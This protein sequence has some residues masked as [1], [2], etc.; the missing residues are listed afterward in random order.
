MIDDVAAIVHAD[1]ADEFRLAR[2]RIDLDFR[3]V[4]AGGIG[5][6]RGHAKHRIEWVVALARV[7]AGKVEQGD[8]Q[9]GAFHAV[10]PVGEFDV[11]RR[12]FQ[13][14]RG[15]V[16]PLLHDL[17][18]GEHERA[19]V[20]HQRART[21]GAVALQRRTIRV[22]IAQ[23]DGFWIDAE[24]TSDDFGKHRLVPLTGGAGNRVDDGIAGVAE[25]DEGLFLR[26]RTAARR[27]DEDAARCS[28]QLAA[29]LRL[30][31]AR[32]KAR[33]VGIFQYVFQQSRRVAAVIGRPCRGLEREGLARNEIA[34]AQIDAINPGLQRRLVDEPLDEIAHVGSRRAAIGRR[35]RRV[36]Q[37]HAMQAM[38]HGDLIN[39]GDVARGR[40][41]VGEGAGRRQI[42]AGVENP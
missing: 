12:R 3:H 41:R 18:R 22:R 36:R 34:P 16:A 39:I 15:E 24:L 26:A 33:E 13:M 37:H 30:G 6:R 2:R 35:G 14:L 7:L 38:R 1:I 32:A 25:L 42:A 29:R 21:N 20:R 9:I 10:T 28:A 31:L 40:E 5:A 8:R 19:A 23:R 27:L 11:I 17:A 4:R